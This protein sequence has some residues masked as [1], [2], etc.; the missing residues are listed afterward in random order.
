MV[1]RRSL[2]LV[3]FAA[4][5]AAGVLSAAPKLAFERLALHQY[6]DGPLL[7]A[8]HDFLPGETV[9]FSCRIAGYDSQPAGDNRNVTLSWQ[10]GLLDPG[11][12][13]VE[14]LKTGRLEESLRLQDKDWVP[15]FVV[16]FLLPSFIPGGSYHIP[17]TVKDEIA[18]SE[19]SGDL[20][21]HVRA[22]TIEPSASFVIRNFRFLRNEDDAVGLRP[23]VA[24][25]Q[26]STLWARFEMAGYKF[27][28]N[29]KFSVEYGLA[30]LGADGK[31]LFAQPAAA[32]ES[33][34]SFYPQLRVP[35]ALSLHLENNVPLAS[36]TL[37]LTV[38]DKIGGDAVELRESFRV[39]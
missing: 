6:E 16:S 30:I 22:E 38:R 11:R 33:K 9:W 13:P 37:V 10:A 15:K 28:A 23:P 4:V 18:G 39:E 35:G 14:P 1:A 3:L 12:I 20:E 32:A 24:Y 19:I 7:P 21:F 26:G 36:Y 25:K 2:P 5:L 34:E 31:E 17:V 29:N 27:E 8:S